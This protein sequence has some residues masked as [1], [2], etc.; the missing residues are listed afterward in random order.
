VV[1]VLVGGVGDGFARSTGRSAVTVARGVLVLPV[2]PRAESFA[3]ERD[4]RVR[5]DERGFVCTCV[6]GVA[7]VSSGLSAGLAAGFAV[8]LAALAFAAARESVEV[9][10][11]AG[12]G[13]VGRTGASSM[14]QR[15][16]PRS[17]G[18]MPSC[19]ARASFDHHA[20]R[21]SRRIMPLVPSC[22]LVAAS[23][24]PRSRPAPVSDD[25]PDS[26][27]PSRQA[28]QRQVEPLR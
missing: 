27:T 26:S 16:S 20:L 28:V 3:P 1:V 22:V 12:R 6:A 8:G 18:I 24:W 25:I 5:A 17:P 15:N 11:E 10:V 14:R 9:V 21:E 7:G 4:V 23:G 2:A 13:V 19:A